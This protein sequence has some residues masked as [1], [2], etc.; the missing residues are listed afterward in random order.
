ML[1]SIAGNDSTRNFPQAWGVVH[2]GQSRVSN[3]AFA[4]GFGLLENHEY[5]AAGLVAEGVEGAVGVEF[6]LAFSAASAS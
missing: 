5:G 1:E 4:N 2:K 3:S 6:E